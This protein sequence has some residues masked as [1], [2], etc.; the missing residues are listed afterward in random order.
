MY[1]NFNWEIFFTLLKN[2]LIVP[3]I[4]NDIVLIKT[5]KGVSLTLT[6][7]I[8]NQ[9]AKQLK[10]DNN[11]LTLRQFI[12]KYHHSTM[13]KSLIKHVY[14][15]IDIEDIDFNPLKKLAKISDFDTF[16]N[17]NFDGFLEDT[18]KSIRKN[19]TIQ[20][21]NM[22]LNSEGSKFETSIEDAI[23]FNV[24]GNIRAKSGFAKTG[25][26]FL[27]YTFS[28]KENN[29]QNK[30]LQERTENKSFLFLGNDLPDWLIPTFMR[31][32]TNESFENA[33]NI[34]FIVENERDSMTS[35]SQFINNFNIEYY[36]SQ[37]NYK[38]NSLSF[39]DEMYD[40]WKQLNFKEIP[41]K[42][43]KSVFINASSE[44]ISELEKLYNV[45]TKNGIEVYYNKNIYSS[46]YLFS[47]EAEDQI[48][49]SNIFIT[50]VSKESIN[51]EK[52]LAFNKELE[53]A[54]SQQKWFHDDDDE[55]FI[56]AYSLG[57]LKNDNENIPEFLRKLN[58]QTLDYDTI[59]KDVD[60][61]LRNL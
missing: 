23:I 32:I 14:N 46:P 22:S 48:K 16:V 2:K 47:K 53:I 24:F 44:N 55:A 17:L 6:E 13:V 40:K 37:N 7:H 35:Y 49:K 51:S 11:N 38:S 12:S 36:K 54:L 21:Q 20:I 5:S 43:N 26:D 27:D 15:D 39:I 30:L 33:E 57:D 31:S 28:L 45:L 50:L 10:L 18:I 58:I 19:E 41:N 9:L 4:G 1:M 61:T 52:N 59:L 29:F 25:S 42:Y 8:T 60:K 56:K 3:V 34:K